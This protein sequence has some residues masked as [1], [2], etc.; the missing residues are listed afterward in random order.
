[1]Q[2][3]A[4]MVSAATFV[5]AVAPAFA[6]GEPAPGKSPPPRQSGPPASQAGDLNRNFVG[7]GSGRSDVGFLSPEQQVVL[8]NEAGG[9]AELEKLGS[10]SQNEK[11]KLQA[12]LQKQWDSLPPAQKEKLKAQLATK[13]T[14]G[15]YGVP[16][17]RSAA[18]TAGASSP[19]GSP[20]MRKDDVRR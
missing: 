18:K 3:I 7:K 10:M 2:R 16:P 5:L 8:A 9:K 4:L 13:M 11:L 20:A 14:E 19:A 17:G 15:A 6:Q 1:M 12:R